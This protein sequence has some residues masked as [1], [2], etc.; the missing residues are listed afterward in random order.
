MLF[1]GPL[2]GQLG[3]RYGSRLPLALGSL[4]AGLSYTWLA[5]GHD[6]RIDIYLAGALL[7][8]GIGLAF[9]AMANLVVEAVPVEVTGVASAI[10]AI[11]RQIGGAIG[12]QVAAALVSASFVAGGRYPA[13]G[14]FTDAFVMSAIASLAALAVCFAIPSRDAVRAAAVRASA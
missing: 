14:G 5:V 2:G 6:A 8:L 1:S 12:A 7:G 9:A 11:M 4:S 13:E 3:A 10:N